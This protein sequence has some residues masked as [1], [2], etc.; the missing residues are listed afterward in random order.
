MKFVLDLK[1]KFKYAF[2]THSM[3]Q[4]IEQ[5]FFSRKR[6][7][8]NFLKWHIYQNLEQI[9]NNYL[10]EHSGDEDDGLRHG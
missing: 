8:L 3:M 6:N 5:I 10:D 2:L 4:L 7:I 1:R 9:E